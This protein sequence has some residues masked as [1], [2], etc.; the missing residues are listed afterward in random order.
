MSLVLNKAK[1]KK[2]TKKNKTKS[3]CDLPKTHILSIQCLKGCVC[4]DNTSILINK[5]K[6]EDTT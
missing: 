2:K 6:G 3:C 1:K 5:H 4:L